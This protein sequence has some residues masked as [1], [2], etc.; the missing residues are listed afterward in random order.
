MNRNVRFQNLDNSGVIKV[1]WQQDRLDILKE[2]N[3]SHLLE[4]LRLAFLGCLSS[5]YMFS[6]DSR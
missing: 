3:S 6:S 5:G 4:T 2:K 1:Q